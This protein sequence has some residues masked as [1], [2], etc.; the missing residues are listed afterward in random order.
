MR[1]CV[2]A[3]V[4][5][6]ADIRGS[7]SRPKGIFAKYFWSR[8]MVRPFCLISGRLSLYFKE[9]MGVTLRTVAVAQL[10]LL[11]LRN[12][13]RFERGV[14]EAR[15]GRLALPIFAPYHVDSPP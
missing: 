9:H 4:A 6:S 11:S 5:P 14:Q 10:T 8:N 1:P 13:S 12:L 15:L 2:V 7:L 3:V